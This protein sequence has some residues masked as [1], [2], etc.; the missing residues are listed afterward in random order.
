[1]DKQSQ[2]PLD[3]LLRSA[4]PA[5]EVSQDFKL[6]LWRKLIKQ[7]AADL[8]KVPVPAVAAALLVGIIGGVW[9]GQGA[10]VANPAV[11]R[12]VARAERW[13]LFGNAPHDSLA[14]AALREMER[15][16]T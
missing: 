14:G 10:G 7:P 4:Y 5:V 6:R 9:S 16:D 3:R 8:W 13:D 15:A 12:V 2:G 1:M 11:A